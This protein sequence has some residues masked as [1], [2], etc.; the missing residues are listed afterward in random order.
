MLCK[1]F[2]VGNHSQHLF[3]FG[4]GHGKLLKPAHQ[5]TLEKS[6]GIQ[7]CSQHHEQ[8]HQNLQWAR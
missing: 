6:L 4:S 8:A 2:G 7:D 5:K 1:G 3:F